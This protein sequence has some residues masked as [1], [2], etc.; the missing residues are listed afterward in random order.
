MRLAEV[1]T[2]Q[3][4]RKEVISRYEETKELYG[5]AEDE[6]RRTPFFL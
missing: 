5:E 3:S 4:A 1:A 6:E 2:R